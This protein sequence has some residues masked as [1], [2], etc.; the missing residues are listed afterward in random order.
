MEP[1]LLLSLCA[2]SF[3]GALS[4]GALFHHFVVAKGGESPRL[5][6][7]PRL[8]RSERENGA[9]TEPVGTSTRSPRLSVG[10]SEAL[11][12]AL[13]E[14]TRA[15]LRAQAIRG[16]AAYEFCNFDD[17]ERSRGASA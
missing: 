14:S 15:L 4:L 5:P 12:A 3:G 7:P 2:T 8:E 16:A 13:D 9:R 17:Y 6:S 11:S 10:A 1:I